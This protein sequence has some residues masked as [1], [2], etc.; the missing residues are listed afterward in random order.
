MNFTY[1]PNIADFLQHVQAC[2]GSVSYL[3]DQGRA[4]DLKALS[5]Q[6]AGLGSHLGG[7]LRNLEVCANRHEDRMILMRYMAEMLCR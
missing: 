1:I 6:M 2:S 7:E 5:S 4:H 3:D